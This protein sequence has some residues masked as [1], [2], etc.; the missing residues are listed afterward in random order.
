MEEPETLVC[1]IKR[2][3]EC[4]GLCFTVLQSYSLTVLQSY[5]HKFSV[6]NKRCFV[7]LLALVGKFLLSGEAFSPGGASGL[8]RSWVRTPIP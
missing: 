2:R 1:L 8:G 6:T 7:T 4:T 3:E 5:S